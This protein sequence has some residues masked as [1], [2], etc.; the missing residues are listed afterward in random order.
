[1]VLDPRI[2]LMAQPANTGASLSGL[3]DFAQQQEQNTFARNR[4]AQQD[5]VVA[6]DKAYNRNMLEQDR[7]YQKQQ[8]AQQNARAWKSLNMQEKLQAQALARGEFELQDAREQQRFKSTVL[9]AAQLGSYLKNNDI[10]GAKNFLQTRK[11]NL[12]KRAG[13]GEN[14]DTSETDF[15]LQLLEKDPKQLM[16]ATN[17]MIETGQLVGILDIP[18]NPGGGT[19]ELV[20]RLMKENPQMSYADALYQVQT[21]N[22]KDTVSNNGLIQPMAGAV[23]TTRALKSAESQGTTQGK[24]TAEAQ[25]NL[26]KAV[27][28]AQSTL[29]ILD[30]ALN[31]PGMAKNFGVQGLVPNMPGGDAANA[32]A[33]LSQIQGGAFLTAF[34]TLKGG[35]HITEVE[36]QKATDA[37]IRMSK[38]QSFDAFQDAAEDYKAVINKGVRR[39]RMAASGEVFGNVPAKA[40]PS[41]VIDFNSLPE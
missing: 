27:D 36:G 4:M 6:E 24:I 1:M 23:E 18:G 11:N 35:G 12:M 17:S 33:L 39:A 29:S 10:E 34:E 20:D 5:A 28:N 41:G 9:G 40:G 25:S 22:R 32:N 3:V 2:P 16:E 15:A 38:A 30:K 19:G 13:S 31:S 7:A 8:D 37:V 14:V 26:P 21:G